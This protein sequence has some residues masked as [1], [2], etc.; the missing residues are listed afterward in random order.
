MAGVAAVA[1]HGTLLRLRRG[2]AA[3][4]CGRVSGVCRV[5]ERL[6][7]GLACLEGLVDLL[8]QMCGHG[9][10]GR[11]VGVVGSSGCRDARDL[12]SIRRSTLGNKIQHNGFVECRGK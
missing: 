7:R 2:R 12:D 6:G 5:A 11:H 1:V 3:Q 9:V 8:A 4:V 10:G